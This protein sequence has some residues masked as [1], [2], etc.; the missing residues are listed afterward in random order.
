[1]PQSRRAVVRTNGAIGMKVG[2]A[3]Y[4]LSGVDLTVLE[5]IDP[6]TALVLLSE[7]GPDV[8]ACMRLRMWDGF[9]KLSCPFTIRA[10]NAENTVFLRSFR[11]FVNPC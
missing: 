6:N 7:I 3:L 2:G 4:R 11:H 8:V 1:M 10:G 5:A 9:Q